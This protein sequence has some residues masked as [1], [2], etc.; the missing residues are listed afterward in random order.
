MRHYDQW[1]ARREGK[2]K[3]R[4]DS[5][6]EQIIEKKTRRKNKGMRKKGLWFCVLINDSQVQIWIDHNGQK[7]KGV[8][9]RD[10][11]ELA[12]IHRQ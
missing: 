5:K 2:K 4:F 9:W 10:I 8:E 7:K 3:Q 1:T 6:R 12:K 11:Y